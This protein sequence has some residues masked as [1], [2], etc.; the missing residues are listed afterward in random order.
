MY[1]GRLSLVADLLQGLFKEAYALHKALLE[2][3]DSISFDSNAS[4]EEVSD[5]V[6][7]ASLCFPLPPSLLYSA[8]IVVFIYL[9]ELF[10]S[11]MLFFFYSDSQPA[12]HV[13]HNL[14]PGHSTSCKHMEI[15]YQV[16]T[17]DSTLAFSCCIVWMLH[18]FSS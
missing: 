7:G 14:Q 3:L 17:A 13:L 4:E 15:P 12:G 10:N 16:S 11:L 1:C 18:E 2:L 8:H 6:T 5:I 9:H